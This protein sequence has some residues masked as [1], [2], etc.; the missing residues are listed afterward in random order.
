MSRKTAGGPPKRALINLSADDV[1]KLKSVADRTGLSIPFLVRRAIKCYVD[2][3]TLKTE[4]MH[5]EGED[6]Q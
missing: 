1:D 4:T 3:G 2:T 5:L 6:G